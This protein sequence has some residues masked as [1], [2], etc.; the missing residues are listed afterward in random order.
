MMV[1]GVGA[2]TCAP[3][4]GW[5]VV[6]RLTEVTVTAVPAGTHQ[7]CGSRLG[8]EVLKARVSSFTAWLPCAWPRRAVK[9]RSREAER[10]RRWA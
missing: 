10:R 4:S 7:H 3:T 1:F 5:S 6:S 2:S 9:P 8:C